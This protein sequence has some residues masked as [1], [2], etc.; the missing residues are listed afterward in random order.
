MARKPT[1][2]DQKRGQRAAA[3]DD[4]QQ[5]DRDERD[6]TLGGPGDDDQDDSDRTRDTPPSRR[7]RQPARTDPDDDQPEMVD[8]I[9]GG[10]TYRMTKDAAAAV[11]NNT[12]DPAKHRK[13]EDQ[14]AELMRGHKKITTPAK[15]DDSDP[16][17]LSVMLF[18]DTAKALKLIKK[19]AVEEAEQKV[20]GKYVQAESEKLFWQGFYKRYDHLEDAKWVVD[21]V[22][23][24]NL[25]ALADTPVEEAAKKI[26]A[27]ADERIRSLVKRVATPSDRRPTARTQI[28]GGG[29]SDRSDRG[30]QPTGRQT[31][32]RNQEDRD[33]GPKTL[34]DVLRVRAKARREAAGRTRSRRAA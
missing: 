4:D 27:L 1:F 34:S 2:K 8:V 14:V 29:D 25:R 6:V 10:K 12:V 31:P 9:L 3:Q 5:D 17:G 16:D 15:D 22:F 18:T 19:Q 28:E 33:E 32:N 11:Q 21:D 24:Q 23:Q 30:R 20:T 26:A 7:N 13:L